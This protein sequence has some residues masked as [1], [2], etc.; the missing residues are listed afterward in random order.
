MGAPLPDR[1]KRRQLLLAAAV[2]H[3]LAEAAQAAP[4]AGSEEAAWRRTGQRG[5]GGAWAWCP[6]GPSAW[7][8]AGRLR[9]HPAS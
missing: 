7:K 1:E 9:R 3:L 6:R 8:L 4:H 5:L 2:A